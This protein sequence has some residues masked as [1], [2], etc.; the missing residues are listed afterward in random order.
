[1]Y[2]FL[3]KVTLHCPLSDGFPP[4]QRRSRGLLLYQ[5]HAMGHTHS[6][7]LSGPSQSLH[8]IK[9]NTHN[10]EPSVVPVGFEPA[11][12]A[13]EGRRS[14]RGLTFGR[15][16]EHARFGDMSYPQ[17]E[18][19]VEVSQRQHSLHQC[20]PKEMRVAY[21]LVNL[22]QVNGNVISSVHCA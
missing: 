22:F 11:I 19:C 17:W 18:H 16:G 6:V 1:L 9:H 7:G 21:H 10:K 2:T 15:D 5:S 13:S 8:L 20:L 14:T 3:C 4:S 12:P